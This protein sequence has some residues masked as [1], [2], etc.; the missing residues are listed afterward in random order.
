MITI[1]CQLF[2]PE[3]RHLTSNA[4]DQLV[5]MLV[6]VILQDLSRAISEL[7]GTMVSVST[8]MILLFISYITI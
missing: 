8:L 7:H 4:N 1:Y 5:V 3:P 2:K 6:V